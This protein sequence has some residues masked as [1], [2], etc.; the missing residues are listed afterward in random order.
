MLSAIAFAY[1]CEAYSRILE[2]ARKPAERARLLAQY[3]DG[4]KSS[5]ERVDHDELLGILREAIE[6]RN[7]WKRILA[8][9]STTQP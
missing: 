1:A 3:A 7:G 9:C 8:R 2:Q 5:D 4:P 6:A